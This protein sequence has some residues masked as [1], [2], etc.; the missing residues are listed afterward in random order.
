M[1]L[2]FLGLLWLSSTGCLDIFQTIEIG[3]D[4]V[5][6]SFMRLKIYIKEEKQNFVPRDKTL[7]LK[8][9]PGVK[10]Q[11]K[12][13]S[14]D[15]YQGMDI[16]YSIPVSK[17]KSNI[18]SLT[19]EIYQPPIIDKNGQL[20]FVFS[21]DKKNLENAKKGEDDRMAE[22]ILGMFSYKMYFPS[23]WKPKSAVIRIFDSNQS[24][25]LDVIPAGNGVL[26][27]F[28]M[29]YVIAGSILTLSKTEKIDTSLAKESIDKNIK[30]KELARKKEEE[31]RKKEQELERKR[32]E[33]YEKEEAKLEA[34]RKKQQQIDD[35]N[36]GE[37]E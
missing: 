5:L 30:E 26:V 32:Q 28:P 7:S 19:Q 16:S 31:E 2:V 20:I 37:E 22:G 18:S 17:L 8:D 36:D 9:Y 11:S 1:K 33:E 4:N 13:I 21:T 23:D 15:N 24:I 3:K 12:V 27:D 34:E 6:T 25:S 29:R 10:I 35:S 14:N